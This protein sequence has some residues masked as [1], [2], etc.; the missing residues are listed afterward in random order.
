MEST[1]WLTDNFYGEICWLQQSM[2]RVQSGP[3]RSPDKII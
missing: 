1:N 3:L 2:L